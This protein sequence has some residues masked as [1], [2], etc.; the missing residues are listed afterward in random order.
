MTLW[1]ARLSAA[2]QPEYHVEMQLVSTPS[3]VEGHHQFTLWVVFS[4][5]QAQ[6]M[7]QEVKDLLRV[8]LLCCLCESK[9]W[10]EHH[11]GFSREP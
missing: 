4:Q 8:M 9:P 3:I 6:S 11:Y 5:C 7:K 2:V 10:L 1:R